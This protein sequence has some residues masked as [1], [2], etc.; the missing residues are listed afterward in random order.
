M[1]TFDLIDAYLFNFTSSKYHVSLPKG[2]CTMVEEMNEVRNLYWDTTVPIE[3]VLKACVCNR[4]GHQYCIQE[5][6]IEAAVDALMNSVFVCASTKV[7]FVDKANRKL[8]DGFS[9]FEQLYDFVASV[10][11]NIKGVGSLTV[12]DT[13]KRIG[14][15]FETPIYPKQY[16][17]LSAGAMEGAKTLLGTKSLKFR[18]PVEIF[19]PYFGTLPSIFIEDILCIFKAVFCTTSTTVK[20]AMPDVISTKSCVFLMANASE[21]ET[22]DE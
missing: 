9:D 20:G 17:Y 16:V 22:I 11:G 5:D 3:D 18:E 12:Y 10:I 6:A 13:A 4:D 1:T 7:P 8:Y 14:H 15:L 21:S 2:C 19:K